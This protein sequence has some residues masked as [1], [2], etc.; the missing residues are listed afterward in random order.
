MTGFHRFGRP[1]SRGTAVGIG[2]DAR[3]FG[4][5]HDGR[6][7]YVN[8]YPGCANPYLG[9]IVPV[10]S[11]ASPVTYILPAMRTGICNPVN[12]FDPDCYPPIVY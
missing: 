2:R 7:G 3:G 11:L 8:P 5:S 6:F 9:N 12:P 4:N 1:L 10:L